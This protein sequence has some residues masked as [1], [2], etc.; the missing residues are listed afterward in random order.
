MPVSSMQRATPAGPRSMTTPSASSTSAEPAADEA[1]RPPCLHTLAPAPATTRAAMV[2][3]LME[4]LRSPPVPQVSTTSSGL[5]RGSG[6]AWVSMART[7]PVIS[8]TVSPLMRKA[9]TKA[10]ICAGVAAPARTSPRASRGLLRGEVALGQETTEHGGPSPRGG[11]GVLVLVRRVRPC[12]RHPRRCPRRVNPTTGRGRAHPV[13]PAR[14]G[15]GS[16]PPRW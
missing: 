16:C 15:P 13:P 4:R 14:A 3:T 5:G 6:S 12:R 10:A 9:V 1:A 2:D 7:K 11:E 8:S